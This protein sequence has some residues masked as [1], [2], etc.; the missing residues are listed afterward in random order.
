MCGE[1]KYST[2]LKRRLRNVFRE[3][4]EWQTNKTSARNRIGSASDTNSART[5]LRSDRLS[6][7]SG[8]LFVG[9]LARRFMI[10]CFA[11]FAVHA[12]RCETISGL[13]HRIIGSED[14]LEWRQSVLVCLSFLSSALNARSSAA[15]GGKKKREREWESK[16]WEE[17]NYYL[18]KRNKSR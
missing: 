18:L 11:S 12:A 9:R 5:S 14:T 16:R 15:V 3:K 4:S 7:L 8:A 6:P 2:G 10:H 1:T 13:I 17:E